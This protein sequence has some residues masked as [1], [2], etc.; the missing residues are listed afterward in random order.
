MPEAIDA[1][2]TLTASG[3]YIHSGVG[4]AANIRIVSSP[5]SATVTS[6]GVTFPATGQQ[7]PLGYS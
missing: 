1:S 5:T 7:W 6:G 3:G 2:A 4:P